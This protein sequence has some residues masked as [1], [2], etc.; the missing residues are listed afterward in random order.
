MPKFKVLAVKT[1]DLEA[2]VEAN[3]AE[4]ALSLV[5]TEF[6]VDDFTVTNVEFKF[7]PYEAFEVSDDY[8]IEVV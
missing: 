4:E 5:D 3:S 7:T 6:I 8:K 1:I 2:V